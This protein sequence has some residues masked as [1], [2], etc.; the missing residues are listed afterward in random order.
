[1][2]LLEEVNSQ[3]GH[4]ALADDASNA[5]LSELLNEALEL[6]LFTSGV[7]EEIFSVL[8]EN[9]TL[10]LTLLH[11]NV[12]V[13]NSNLSLDDTFDLGL[14]G[15]GNDNTLDDLGVSD[16]TA[17]NLLNSDGINIEF[18][19]VLG[20][21]VDGSLTN[22]FGEEFFLTELL[23]GNN[24]SDALDKFYLVVGVGELGC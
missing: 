5:G 16:T 8:K 4:G 23:G 6:I 24:S 3:F 15:L 13:E 1:M 2:V 17:E 12:G 9:S 21:A 22:E 7:V 18:L 20:H 10:G 19:C 11:L 14:G